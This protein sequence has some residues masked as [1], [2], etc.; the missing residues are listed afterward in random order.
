MRTITAFHPGWKSLAHCV[1]HFLQSRSC[2]G[3]KAAALE[4]KNPSDPRI[5]KYRQRMAETLEIIVHLKK[6]QR[7]E[8]GGR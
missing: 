5:V 2:Y 4:S 1:V 7:I 6:I 8:Q 3:Q